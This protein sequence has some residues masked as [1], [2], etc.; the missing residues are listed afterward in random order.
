[1]DRR[2]QGVGAGPQEGGDAL[3]LLG[4]RTEPL[5]LGRAPHPTAELPKR[6]QCAPQP[7]SSSEGPG[8]RLCRGGCTARSVIPAKQAREPRVPGTQPRIPPPPVIGGGGRAQDSEDTCRRGP[9]PEQIS[10]PAQEHPDPCRLG[11]AEVTVGADS[12][13]GELAA[14]SAIVPPGVT[15]CHRQSKAAREQGLH[16]INSSH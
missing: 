15:L 4:A 11:A 3:R 1:M 10:S 5:P 13:A 12:R 8:R 14:A 6:L 2:S 16:R 9:R 7:G